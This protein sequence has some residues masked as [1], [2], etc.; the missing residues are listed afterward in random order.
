[1]GHLINHAAHGRRVFKRP[2]AMH[3]VE[4]QTNQRLTLIGLPPQRT[5]NLLDGDGLVSHC[6]I[7]FQLRAQKTDWRAPK[8]LFKNNPGL[9][10]PGDN[11]KPA[12]LLSDRFRLLHL[13]GCFRTAPNNVTDFLTAALRHHAGALLALQ[14]V[15]CRPYHVIGI[16]GPN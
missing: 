5:A 16:G 12:G 10:T 14:S 1:M 7:L 15:E 4:A 11:S 3:F 6:S 8:A 9:K 13:S 2:P